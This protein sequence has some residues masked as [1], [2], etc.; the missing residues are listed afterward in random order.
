MRDKR[1]DVVWEVSKVLAEGGGL[2]WRRQNLEL[3]FVWFVS[4][5]NGSLIL[6]GV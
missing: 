4:D 3:L 1:G 6:S 5:D 2:E